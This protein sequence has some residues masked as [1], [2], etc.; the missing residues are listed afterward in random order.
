MSLILPKRSLS[1]RQQED[2]GRIRAMNDSRA[3]SAEMTQ[4]S[5]STGERQQ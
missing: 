1:R 5:E 4:L 2:T 3:Y